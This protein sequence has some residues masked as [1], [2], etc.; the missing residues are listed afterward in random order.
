MNLSL[1][2][3]VWVRHK[4]LLSFP[5]HLYP[6]TNSVAEKIPK[7]YLYSLES[8]SIHKDALDNIPSDKECFKNIVYEF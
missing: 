1:A 3:P 4:L 8:F 5:Q 2:S 7:G 6:I